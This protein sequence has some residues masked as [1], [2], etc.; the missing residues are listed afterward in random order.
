M[1][2]FWYS[3]VLFLYLTSSSPCS[4]STITSIGWRITYR[5]FLPAGCFYTPELLRIGKVNL[6]GGFGA[7]TNFNLSDPLVR[8][9]HEAWETDIYNINNLDC[10][11]NNARASK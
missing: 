11:T 5:D 10:C 8:E 7:L 4:G 2:P 9:L 6:G 3:V 1:G